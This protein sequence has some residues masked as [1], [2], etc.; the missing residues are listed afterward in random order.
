[1]YPDN[2]GEIHTELE[3]P[4]FSGRGRLFAVASSGRSFG[5]AEQKIEI[6]REIV[7]E[8]GLPRFAA[9]EDFFV[10]P[11]SVFNTSTENKNVKVTL[12]PEGLMLNESFKELNISAGSKANFSTQAKALG[13]SNKAVLRV[14][15]EWE[16]KAFTDEIEMP[17]RSAW[18]NITLGGTGIFEHGTSK[19]DIPLNDFVGD[20][21]GTLTLADTPAVNL[22]QAADFLRNY[23]YG[24]LEQTISTAWPFL[25]LPDAIAELDPMIAIDSSIKERTEGAINRIQSMQLYD[26]SFS[27]WPGNSTPYSWGSVYAA[28]FLL[29]AKNAGI[30]F[31]EEMFTGVINWIRQYLP[32]MPNYES[33]SDEQDDITTKAYAVYVLTLNGEKPLGWLEYL[34]ENK[35]N[36]RPSGHIYLAGA[37]SLIDGNSDALRNLAIGTV[38]GSSGRTLES[39][40]RN[41]AILLSMWLDIEPQAPEVTELAVRL[42]DL[43]S[44]SEWYS[45]QDN[46]MALIALSRYNVEAAGA[47]SNIQARLNTD[48]SDTA[49]LTYN[50]NSKPVSVKV[51]ELP[52]NAGILIEAEGDGQGCYSW[53]ING[54]PKAQP[55]PERKNINIECMYFDEQGNV[56]NLSQPIEHG[57]IIQVV[58][59]IKP[60]MTIN[61]LAV[62]YLLP[63]GFELENPRLDDGVEENSG[64]YGVVNDIRDDRLM[65]FFDR[66][67]AERSY[68]FKMR[69]VTRG[70]FKTPQISAYGMYD[71]SVRFTGQPQPDMRIR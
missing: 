9:P 71:S 33:D 32:S 47:K 14:K 68:G 18:P 38:S 8:T 22:T 1:M 16:G 34:R 28:H 27:M 59:G 45:T 11:V 35:N 70:T 66:I 40:T 42:S 7:T 2:K 29:K 23:P 31:P 53:S 67:K 19:L 46:A 48:T 37:Q 17:V 54:F 62:N 5:K 63:A 61:N 20:V 4:E 24:C 43:G 44:K 60:S 10:I 50:S 13:G 3:I 12:I 36:L 51:N 25:I 41:I 55:K 49:I 56:L 69:A 6:A 15:T 52:R 26:G 21:E 30:N 65:L 58:L 39:E 57:K 64:S